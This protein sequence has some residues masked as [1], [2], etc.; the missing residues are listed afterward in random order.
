MTDIFEKIAA[1]RIIPVLVV[2]DIA[3]ARPLAAALVEGGL[4][5][6][7]V[8][9]RTP[10]ALDIAR[11]VAAVD[12]AIVGIGTVLNADHCKAAI[13]LPPYNWA[14]YLGFFYE[15]VGELGWRGNGFRTRTY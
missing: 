3:S 5:I 10:R 11:E 7:E 15:A 2:G 12:G 9:M 8:T 1:Q 14:A 13:V 4:P 6:V